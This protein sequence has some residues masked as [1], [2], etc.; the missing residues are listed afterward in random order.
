M[1]KP[2]R[3]LA[4][5]TTVVVLLVFVGG[6]VQATSDSWPMFQ[7][8]AQLS[9]FSLDTSLSIPLTQGWTY[10]AA[11]LISSAPTI[12][13]GTVY[14]G[15]YDGKVHALDALQGSAKWPQPFSLGIA[16]SFST[17]AVDQG[18]V[19]V[20]SGGDLNTGVDAF[21]HALDVGTGREL[22]KVRL[23]LGFQTVQSSPIVFDGVVYVGSGGSGAGSCPP[24]G[25]KLYAVNAATGAILPGW[26]VPIV[27]PN[28]CRKDILYAP[29]VTQNTVIVGTWGS[30]FVCPTHR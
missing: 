13:N 27:D 26:P 29:A 28:E 10:T 3:C 20:V 8:D 22:W 1:S 12:V 16:T 17:A 21:L 9:G 7:H 15:S 2:C 4:A 5:V 25:H 23:A 6:N 11:A 30:C 14:V 19:Y 24:E 18:R